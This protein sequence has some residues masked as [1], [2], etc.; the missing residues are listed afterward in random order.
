MR[1]RP[2]PKAR[3]AAIILILLVAGVVALLVACPPGAGK[4]TVPPTETRRPSANASPQAQ[5]AR[6]GPPG[7]PRPEQQGMLAVIIDDAGYNLGELQA[8]LDLPG[9]LTISV[10]PNLP[11]SREA[12][13]RVLAAGK[14]LIL[15]CPM[16]ATGGEDPGPGALRT[17]QSPREVE[18]LLA[19]AFATVPGAQG[20]NNH[21]GSRATADEALMSTVLGFL[22]REGK[23][24]V[25]SRTTADTVGP[26]VARE[27]GVPLLQRDVFVDESTSDA[28]IAAAFVKGVSEA[29]TR[30][31]AVLI[32]HVQNRGVIDILRAEERN[33]SSEGVRLA[34]LTDVL[35]EQERETGQ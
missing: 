15:H 13:R 1:S 10:L 33:L 31:F 18:S 34:R 17:D 24:F 14:D 9:P 19:A 25:D 3:F 5:A 30:G 16:E 11:H 8:F 29:K 21:M 23:F 32:G 26:R 2:L 20:M 35:G 12:A 6:T 27:L 22:K 28:D 4:N 7:H